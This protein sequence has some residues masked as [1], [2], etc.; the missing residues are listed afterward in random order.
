M[1]RTNE[2]TEPMKRVQARLGRDLREYLTE[3]YATSTAGQIAVDLG[4]SE[5]AVTIWMDRLGIERR[6]PGQRPGVVA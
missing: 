2:L 3:R 6:F 4:I 1:D 5:S